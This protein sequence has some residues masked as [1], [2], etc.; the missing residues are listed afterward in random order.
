MSNKK[1]CGKDH[2]HK[3]H[4]WTRTVEDVVIRWDEEPKPQ[5]TIEFETFICPGV[6]A[7]RLY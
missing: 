3:E 6:K 5:D 1:W 4:M 2:L 7:W